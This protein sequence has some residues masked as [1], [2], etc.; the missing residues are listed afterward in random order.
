[1][2]SEC[3]NG[4]TCHPTDCP[5]GCYCIP[6]S[7]YCSQFSRGSS[8]T[9]NACAVT[10]SSTIT[11]GVQTGTVGTLNTTTCACT[12]STSVKRCAKGYYDT[13]GVRPMPV[14]GNG[15]EFYVT[16]AQTITC[17]PCPKIDG[18][19]PSAPPTGYSS[20]N[21]DRG[22]LNAITTC[23]IEPSLSIA[24]TVGTYSFSQNCFYTK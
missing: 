19:T 3:A 7:S 16:S 22:L 23:Y 20:N 2:L 4:T 11:N 6:N 24:D 15:A 14:Q 13:S 21:T 8:G 1:M 5:T 18:T 12:G 17:T 9:C 10:W